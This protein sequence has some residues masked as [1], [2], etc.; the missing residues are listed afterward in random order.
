MVHYLDS[1]MGVMYKGFKALPYGDKINFIVTADH[2]MTEVSEDRFYCIDDYIKPE[3]VEHVAASNPTSIFSK[4][5]CRDSILTALVGLEHLNVWKKEDV[6][7]ELNY[8]TSER[9]GDVIVAPD[10]G[11][12]F[13][14]KPRTIA[15]CHGYFP[16]EPDMQVAF[17][18]CGPDF[19]QGF[20]N[21]DKFVNVDLYPLLA[22]LLGIK[23]EP[24]DGD[25]NRVKPLLK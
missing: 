14:R 18:A 11:W 19:K 10:L 21:P 22:H 3:W 15:A 5:G 4:P 24:T 8:G 9:L 20:V 16:Q 12:Q 23:P 2:G 1:L 17:R 25:F 7:A 13:D 6:P